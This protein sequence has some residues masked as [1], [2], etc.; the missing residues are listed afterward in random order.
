MGLLDR[1][2]RRPSARERELPE[3]VA[4]TPRYLQV[5]IVNRCNLR[6][7]MCAIKELTAARSRRALDVEGFAAIVGQFPLLERVDLQGIGEPLVNPHLES[8]I[9]WC[10]QRGVEVGFVTNGLLFDADRIEAVLDAGPSYVVFSV[11][12]VDP[13]VFDSIRPGADIGTLLATIRAMVL[14]KRERGLTSPHIGIMSV[15]MKANLP[16]MA[17]VVDTAAELG[18]DGL[19]VKGL[20]P[21]PNPD[22]APDDIVASL[23]RVR[24]AVARHPE[25]PV[26]VALGHDDGELRCRWPWSAAYVTAEGDLTPCCNCPDAR[27]VS[28]GNLLERP[29]AEL[30][31]DR[32]YREFR[33]ELRDGMPAICA[34]CPDY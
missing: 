21:R 5:E 25:L 22:V 13:A 9:R 12:S 23:A 17:D 2:L 1:L 8:I 33:R 6:C 7:V 24:E 3:R 31:N 26:T 29:F 27:D 20:N 30:W 34:G 28:F 15:A 4:A 18:V 14:R 10:R 16:L 32:P 19:T 11:D